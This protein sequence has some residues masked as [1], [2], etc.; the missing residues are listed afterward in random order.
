MNET[1]EAL[2][3]KECSVAFVMNEVGEATVVVTGEEPFVM[4]GMVALVK[5][6]AEQDGCSFN[7]AMA[8]IQYYYENC[9]VADSEEDAVANI[10]K[11]FVII[12]GKKDLN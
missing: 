6:L 10:R 5:D 11:G 12:N 4:Y 1:M 2:K 7:E 3:E 8:K 9:E